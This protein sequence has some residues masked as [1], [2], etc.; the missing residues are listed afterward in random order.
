MNRRISPFYFLALISLL[1][2]G[3]YT[4][5]DIVKSFGTTSALYNE[6]FLLTTILQSDASHD[7][8]MNAPQKKETLYGKNDL[9]ARLSPEE[10]CPSCGMNPRPIMNASQDVPSPCG[11]SPRP[12]RISMR[13]IESNGVGYNQGYTTLEGF[14]SPT[15]PWGEAWIPFLDVRGHVFNNGK[16]A[17][18]LGIGMRYQRFP[19]IWGINTY[20]DYRNTSHQHYNQ[21]SLGL[22]S[23]GEIWDFRMNGY[24]PVGDKT[25]SFFHSR[26]DEFEGHY[27]IISRKRE[28]A[29]QGANAE[30]GAHV[31]TFK[32]VPLY[33]AAGPYYLE[34][35]G[36]VAWG[37]ELRAAVDIF[38][39]V[40]LEGNTSYDNV[41]GWIGQGQ[42]SVN[43]SLGKKRQISQ[44]KSKSCSTAL[45]LSQRALQRVDRQEIIAVDRQ[46]QREKA[47]NPATG[48]PYFFVF[49]NNES[50]SDGTFESP[51]TTLPTSTQSKPG[52]VIY[53]FAGNGSAYDININSSIDGFVM[54]DNQKLWGS[55]NSHKA[56]TQYGSVT[57]PVL[58]TNMPILT[59]SAVIPAG[60]HVVSL[61]N[62]CEVSGMHITGTTIIAG[63]Y[64]LVASGNIQIQNNWIEISNT[65]A[66]SA[67]FLETFI[68]VNGATI[69]NNRISGLHSTSDGIGIQ[70]VNFNSPNTPIVISNNQI[71]GV[72]ASTSAYGIKATNNA[73]G[74]SFTV[75]NNQITNVVGPTAAASFGI[76]A[77]NTSGDL[78]LTLNNNSATPNIFYY[79]FGGTLNLNLPFVGNTPDPMA[80][81]GSGFDGICSP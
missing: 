52:D 24:L 48:Q 55:G 22:E 63:I 26:F 33:F 31:N 54:Q 72:T 28:F 76:F 36:E 3:F 60:A 12:M 69:S 41:F 7:G 25:S 21:I 29:M 68:G 49:V 13:H 1:I 37:G 56:A 35:Q 70:I 11:M 64:G 30:V 5:D 53:V 14:F 47:I 65:S 66:S 43:I 75:N 8:G 16:L 50:H 40:R 17:A 62:N 4:D 71:S 2:I 39:Y 80:Y 32:N 38:D 23:L 19:R 46:K 73:T 81:L 34:G 27:M 15:K 9:W 6:K 74:S 10:V 20:Y 42:V 59:N 78:C 61:A 44:K 67:I 45:A 58:S 51:Y 57:I 18:N 79:K 77:Q